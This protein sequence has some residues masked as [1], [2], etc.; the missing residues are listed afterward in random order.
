VTRPPVSA[1]D[2]DFITTGGADDTRSLDRPSL[3]LHCLTPCWKAI[4][5]LA[6]QGSPES[7]PFEVACMTA[8]PDTTQLLLDARAGNRAAFDRLFSHVYDA[9]RE[10]AHQRLLKHRP[11]ETLDTT[12]LVHE[13]YL[14]LVDQT[15]A[16]WRDRAHFFALASRAMRF[17]LV[18]YA[19]ARTA[20]KRGGREPDVPLDAVQVAAD[21]RATDLV[22]LAEAL[23]GLTGVSP[24]LGEVVDYRFFGGLTFEEIAEATGMSV[25]TVKRD[26]ARARAWLYRTMQPAA[27]S[28]S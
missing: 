21:E 26:W 27:G 12:A 18:D 16:E 23:E 24:R 17:V 25:P 10:I 7:W 8:E 28:Q 14:R 20:A 1:G 9:L 2:T 11:G 22:A 13:A 3:G 15:R 6:L 5:T 19:R 4:R